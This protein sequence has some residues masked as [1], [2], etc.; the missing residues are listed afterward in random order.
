MKLKVGDR[1]VFKMAGCRCKICREND[2]KLV[3]ITQI[4]TN[5]RLRVRT[6]KG[7]LEIVSNKMYSAIPKINPNFKHYVKKEVALNTKM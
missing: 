5:G 7:G 4:L 6:Q 1:V 3:T 2:G